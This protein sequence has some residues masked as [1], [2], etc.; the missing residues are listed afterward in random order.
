M[1]NEEQK[2]NIIGENTILRDEKGLFKK[3]TPPPN[4]TGRP[5]GTV[6]IVE[7]IKRKLAEYTTEEEK[8]QF[9][10]G[11]VKVIIKKCIVDE[12]VSM[13]RDLVNRIDGLPK[14]TIG[15]ID[16]TKEN[17]I[18]ITEM[19]K[20]LDDDKQQ[21]A[22]DLLESIYELDKQRDT[23]DTLS[24][25]LNEVD[26]GTDIQPKGGDKELKTGTTA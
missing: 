1:E 10:D 3:G 12:D 5:K 9:I 24:D 26:T 4:P 14:Q 11:I 18:P 17:T 21:Q 8:E 2:P 22:V 19:I 20:K 15:V 16:E 13:I 23:G 7:R 6:S 25:G